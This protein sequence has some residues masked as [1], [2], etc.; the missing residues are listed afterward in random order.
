MPTSSS[1]S[2][3]AGGRE[4]DPVFYYRSTVFDFPR[5]FEVAT[6]V[7]HSNCRKLDPCLPDWVLQTIEAS[8]IR[9]QSRT[10][11][12][13]RL[14]I[15][16]VPRSGVGMPRAARGATAPASGAITCRRS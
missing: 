6:I 3:S 16:I 9:L 2:M 15:R 13:R 14:R 8:G 1:R 5:C 4:I 11:A 12:A 7:C 10:H